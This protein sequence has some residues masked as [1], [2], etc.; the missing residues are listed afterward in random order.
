MT[1]GSWVVPVHVPHRRGRLLDR[2]SARS[3]RAG[4]LVPR[5]VL[6]REVRRLVAVLDRVVMLDRR[7]RRLHHHL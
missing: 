6:V 4:Q 2:A 7:L 3:R 5:K 1:A